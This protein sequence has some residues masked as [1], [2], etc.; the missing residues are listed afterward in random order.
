MSL[1]LTE[2]KQ[3]SATDLAEF[4][5]S[6]KLDSISRMRKQDQIFAILKAQARKGEKIKG[7]GVMSLARG[8]SYTGCANVITSLWSVSDKAAAEIMTQFYKNLSAGLAIDQSLS[9]AKLGF[10]KENKSLYHHPY[11]WAAFIPVG[12]SSTN[13][14]KTSKGYWYWLAGGLMLAFLGYFVSKRSKAA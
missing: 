4:A 14:I 11:Y 13:P 3:K 12:N 9:Q 7:E 2:L 5:R 10:I 8:F 1:N 6:L